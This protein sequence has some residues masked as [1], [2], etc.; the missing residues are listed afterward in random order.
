MSTL[1]RRVRLWLVLGLAAAPWLAA[2]GLAISVAAAVLAP[3]ATLGVGGV[4]DGLGAGDADRVAS[5]LWLVGAGIVVAVLQSVSWPLVWFFVEDLGERYAHHHVLR[6]IAGIPTIAHHE[7]PE[8]ADRVAMVRR[9]ARQLGNAGLRLWTDVA[10]IIGDRHLAASCWPRR[11][12]TLSSRLLSPPR[13]A[14]GRV[15]Q[16][17]I[18]AERDNAETIGSPIASSTSHVTPAPGSRCGAAVA[19]ATLLKPRTQP[20]SS[21]SQPWQAR[22]A[23]RVRSRCSVDS[24]GSRCSRSACPGSSPWCR[25]VGRRGW[26]VVL[27]LLVPQIEGM[28]GMLQSLVPRMPCRRPSTSRVWTRWSSMPLGS[29]R[30]PARRRPVS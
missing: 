7:M 16:A 10:A 23:A 29:S 26:L 4:V 13:W 15:F 14:S 8:M 6:V 19:A 18:D 5:G 2:V 21:G 17:R 3:L 27:V 9:H 25:P 24:C 22:P 1:L 28:V 30:P 11:W 12:L 20:S